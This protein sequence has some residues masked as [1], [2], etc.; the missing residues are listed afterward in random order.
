MG[1]EAALSIIVPYSPGGGF[2]VYSRAIVRH[3]PKYLPGK[4]K[5]NVVIQNVTGAGGTVGVS[6]VYHSKPNGYTIGLMNTIGV[7]A[8]S[9]LGEIGLK[10]AALKFDVRDLTYIGVITEN[11]YSLCVG[12]NHMDRCA[13]GYG[14]VGHQYIGEYVNIKSIR[15]LPDS[16]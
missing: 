1:R 6:K 7:C 5:I 14:H 3:L 9:V 2:D 4:K 8:A 10:L 13:E 11:I 15:H 12:I 16:I